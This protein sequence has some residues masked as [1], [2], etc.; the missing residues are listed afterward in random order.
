MTR[1]EERERKER[2]REALLI[3][4]QWGHY[5]AAKQL[6][7]DERDEDCLAS[8]LAAAGPKNG[9]LRRR[10][11]LLK[12]TV[13]FGMMVGLLADKRKLAPLLTRTFTHT[14]TH[15]RTHPT[16]TQTLACALYSSA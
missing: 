16:H 2:E 9:K 13:L 7:A 5:E 15:A 14:H 1:A 10:A 8:A 11:L 3:L 6:K 4:S 12:A